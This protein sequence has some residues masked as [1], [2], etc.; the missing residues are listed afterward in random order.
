MNADF[1][2][3]LKQFNEQAELNTILNSKNLDRVHFNKAHQL[4][5]NRFKRRQSAQDKKEVQARVRNVMLNSISLIEK[6]ETIKKEIEGEHKA[7]T[8]QTLLAKGFS[9]EDIK[10]IFQFEFKTKNLFLK[11]LRPLI[12][13]DPEIRSLLDNRTLQGFLNQNLKELREVSK[14]EL[15][16]EK[17]KSVKLK[18]QIEKA[19]LAAEFGLV[20]S[21]GKGK[22]GSYFVEW[23]SRKTTADQKLAFS[24]IG[25]FKVST[26]NVTF[27]V[28]V[29]N[30][31]KRIFWGQLHYLS[32]KKSAQSQ[33][34]L[35]SYKTSQYLGFSISPHVKM[36]T[37]DGK[38]GTMQ[39]FI[40]GFVEAKDHIALFGNKNNFTP[41]GWRQY[42]EMTL[43]DCLIGNLDRHDE[44]LLIKFKDG[45]IDEIKA[46]D[47]ANSF[48]QKK[49]GRL[50]KIAA[51]NR[52]KWKRF[53]I[54]KEK[55]DPELL[56]EMRTKL[57]PQNIDS[58]IDSIQTD[59]PKFL[60]P[61]MKKLLRERST[62]ILAM[63][64]KNDLTPQKLAEHMPG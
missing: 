46:I 50:I 8:E 36:V 1:I 59:V 21:S 2:S 48:P 9:R 43:F 16:P 18:R 39:R 17:I 47:N 40:Q 5:S 58:L 20:K 10:Q 29:S 24:K 62:N 55:Y 54:S 49:I 53:A 12:S 44:N 19:K 57:Q 34:E 37:L 35:A 7:V 33:A 28:R 4:V 38:F 60:Q 61:Q 27:K 42:Q 56:S 13:K 32:R 31:L 41:E 52:Y 22:T 11:K 45:K 14:D 23:V 6:W 30:L 25:V 64:E 63:A 26:R 51:H 3:A 15:S